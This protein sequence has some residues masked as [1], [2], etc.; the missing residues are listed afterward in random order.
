MTADPNLREQGEIIRERMQ[1]LKAHAGFQE[2]MEAMKAGSNFQ[3]Q[4]SRLAEE[5]TAMMVDPELHEQAE[6]GD[7][8]LATRA[9][10]A[11]AGERGSEYAADHW[12]D[13]LVGKLFDR[14]LQ[15][16]PF[17]S[18]GLVDGATLGKAGHL[19]AP[20][21]RL[22]SRSAF[23]SQALPLP[24]AGTPRPLAG[25]VHSTRGVKVLGLPENIKPGVLIAAVGSMALLGFG[26]QS[27]S[28]SG[29]LPA[30]S[31]L[32]LLANDSS[33]FIQSFLLIFLSEIGDKTFFIAGLLAAKY[34]KILSFTGSIGALGVM[35]IIAV[36]IGQVFHSLPEGF[37]QGIP[38]DDYVAIAAFIYFGGKTL[39]DAYTSPEGSS[40]GIDEE[41]K[42]AEKEVQGATK[43]GEGLDRIAVLAST[44]GLVFAAE[45]GDRSFL[46]TIALSAALNPFA[47]LFGA[48]LAHASATGVAVIGGEL[49]SKYL[50]EKV[51]GYLSGSLFIV[52]AVT[53]ALG[54]F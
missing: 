53:T 15:V 24:R 50:S 28:A 52:F 4:A 38:F 7:A 8:Q 29:L 1:A 39:Y 5:V 27:A 46:S 31:Q 44:F 51:I 37:S 21:S 49:L 2:R 22:S 26:V 23:T 42:E 48:V 54:V 43:D 14:A 41:R 35:S 45:I 47:V 11:A 40:S 20:S 36:A 34:S 25:R 30:A 32:G 6:R 33:G 18:G 12:G 17:H 3:E 16:S 19:S 10:V 9:P 13:N